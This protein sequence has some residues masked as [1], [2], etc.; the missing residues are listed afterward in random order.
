M[1]KHRLAK[2]FL[3]RF[4]LLIALPVFAN[5]LPLRAEN[6][7]CWRGPRGDGTSLEEQVPTSWNGRT[8]E[9]IKWKT[10][11]PGKGH[12][13]PIVWGDHVFVTTCFE[14][15]QRRV[16]FCLD[17]KSGDVRWHEVVAVSPLESKHSLNSF[18]SG[19]PATDGETVFVAFLKVGNKKVPAQNV[20]TP[21]DITLGEM[22]IAAY[23]F[24]GNKKWSKLVG[25]FASCHG[26]CSSPVIYRDKLIINGDHDGDSYVVAL[27][28]ATGET[29]WRTPRELKT[30][31]YVT[32]IIRNVAGKDQMVFSGSRRVVS[33]NPN[34]G[35][36]I[37]RV[38]GPTEQF[39]ASPVYDGKLFYLVGGFPTHHVIAIRPDGEGDV[40]DSHVEWHVT[41]AKAYVPSPVLIDPFLLVADDRGTANCF[42]SKNGER[43]WQERMGKHYSAS[44][45]SAGGLAFFLADDGVTK[46]V[47]P[48]DK[49]E[50]VAK[51]E[52]GEYCFASPAV[53]NGEI[54]I[55]GEENLFCIST[56]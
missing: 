27:D 9:N 49:L 7:P 18:A 15:Q 26:F 44:L 38:D 17:R 25:E 24:N 40:T 46:V 37:W 11:I 14:N 16:L 28:K 6:W 13:S 45:F 12:S 32:P 48:S 51:N 39:V 42:D 23:D 20:G 4:T 36:L 50:I 1:K 30:R 21:R 53:S 52:L 2:N 35:E 10:R 19:T 3:A 54:F 29:V 43:L 8:G 33:L 47:K 41:K 22:L 55:R 34:N 56:K 31:S 5:P